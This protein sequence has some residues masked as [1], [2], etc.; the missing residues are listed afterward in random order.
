MTN[1][2]DNTTVPATPAALAIA[3]EIKT[4]RTVTLQIAQ[5]VEAQIMERLWLIRAEFS[6]D[7]DFGAFT[8]HHLDIPPKTALAYVTTWGGARKNRNLRELAQRKPEQA[9]QLIEQLAKNGLDEVVEQDTEVARLLGLPPKKQAQA[10]RE[11]LDASDAADSGRNPEDVRRIDAL[12]TELAESRVAS[13]A[14][15]PQAQARLLTE[16]LAEVQ[17]E[18]TRRGDNI[19][20]LTRANQ[21]TRQLAIRMADQIIG[22]LENISSAAL[23]ELQ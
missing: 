6:S 8:S 16:Y 17:T 22:A 21:S 5:A 10:L 9:M 12:E 23:E 13:I 4:L 7:E 15:S 19:L 11:L 20:A 2:N 1:S 3:Q 18:L 14:D